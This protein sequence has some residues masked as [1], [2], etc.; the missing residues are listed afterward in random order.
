[1]RKVL[2]SLLMALVV[3]VSVVGCKKPLSDEE[4]A[5]MTVEKFVEY[6]QNSKLDS[7]KEVYPKCT[8]V[9][10]LKFETFSIT[11]VSKWKYSDDIYFVVCNN[12]CHNE[13]GG[14][15]NSVLKFTVNT[16]MYENQDIQYIESSDGLIQLPE[17]FAI[18]L[19]KTGALT[20]TMNDVDI[21]NDFSAF[22]DFADYYIQKMQIGVDGLA[23]LNYTGAEY[24]K[25][26]LENPHPTAC[27]RLN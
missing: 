3:A 20:K 17:D 14:L 10:A 4:K 26:L 13:N 16:R 24:H 27:F 2:F 11:G 23:E 25:Y 19:T 8:F 1:M 7:A 18:F 9:N 5:K 15:I 12:T 21:I 22:T 6:V